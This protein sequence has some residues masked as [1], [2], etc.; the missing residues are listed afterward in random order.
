MAPAAPP[1]TPYPI[2]PREVMNRPGICSVSTGS[3][4]G[5][6]DRSI[7]E[8][9][10]VE[11][12]IGRWRMSVRLRVPVTTTLS[13]GCVLCVSSVSVG[14]SCWAVAVTAARLK[15]KVRYMLLFIFF[16]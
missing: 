1:E 14:D 11:T 8:R 10:I 5:C 15:A 9:S 7:D 3:R 12:V 16:N 2:T 6:I 13:M 4:D